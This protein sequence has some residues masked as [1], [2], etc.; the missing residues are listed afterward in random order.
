MDLLTRR[1]IE[2]RAAAADEI[3][4]ID[5]GD[6]LSTLR[7]PGTDDLLRHGLL[8]LERLGERLG[9]LRELLFEAGARQLPLPSS[10]R[11]PQPVS[12]C[13]RP[14]VLAA[15]TDGEGE[16]FFVNEGR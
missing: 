3:I 8:D 7:N 5:F 16:I 4:G 11:F 14:G 15:A 6:C 12:F 1:G 13:V 2:D 10:R 9:G